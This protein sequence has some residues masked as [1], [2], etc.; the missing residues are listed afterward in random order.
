MDPQLMIVAIVAIACATGLIKTW[1]NKNAGGNRDI[2]QHFD[3]LAKAFM[4]HKK[5]MERRVENLEAIVVEE[6]ETPKSNIDKTTS[7]TQIEAPESN[8]GSLS[9]DLNKNKNRVRS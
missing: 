3:R 6:D 5:D 4:Q 7:T 8:E 1:I 9:N 2:E